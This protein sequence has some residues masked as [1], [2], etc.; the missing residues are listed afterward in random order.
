[1]RCR[2][3][4]LPTGPI[5]RDRLLDATAEVGTSPHLVLAFLPPNENLRGNLAAFAAAWPDAQ[6]VGCEAVTQ[7]ADGVLATSGTAQLFWFDDPRHG[8]EIEILPG[9]HG[10]PPTRRK[11]EALA[12]HIAASDGALLLLDGLRFPSEYLLD[13]LRPEL[14]ARAPLVAGGLASQPVP[15]VGAGARIFCGER[16]LPAACLAILFRGLEMRVEVVS[17]WSPASPV[18]T[19]T[20]AEGSSLLEIEGQPAVVWYRRFFTVNGELAPMPETANRFPLIIEGPR[21]ERQ[22]IY[23]TMRAFDEPTGG[24]TYWGSIEVGDRVRLGMGNDRTLIQTACELRA[25]PAPQAAIL[26]SCVGREEFLGPSAR[27]EV[28]AIHRTLGGV[29]LSGF[30]TFGEIGPTPGGGLAF[31]NQTAIL[32]LLNEVRA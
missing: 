23:R 5:S 32:A 16:V 11:V 12:R 25:G 3:V 22:G 19:V 13:L 27:R 20:K 15:I 4:H 18:Y 24:V 1:M 21:G 10:E 30:F 8:A 28:D 29:P 14:G 6:R 26:Y 7:F 17:G 31:Y 2:T 9:T